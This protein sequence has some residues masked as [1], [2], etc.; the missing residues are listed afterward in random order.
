[1]L[2]ILFVSLDF[3]LLKKIFCPYLRIRY[4]QGSEGDDIWISKELC[5]LEYTNC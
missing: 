2:I 4:R 3:F 5:L 1:M